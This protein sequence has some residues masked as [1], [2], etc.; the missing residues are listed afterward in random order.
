MTIAVYLCG[1]ESK[2]IDTEVIAVCANRLAPGRFTWRK[3][4][5]QISLE[6]IRVF[7]SDAKKD[8]NGALVSGSGDR[9]WML[10]PAGCQL[11]KQNSHLSN[12]PSE[13]RSRL[14]ADEKR[15]VKREKA[16][17]LESTAAQKV[18]EG[19]NTEI[20]RREAEQFFRIDDYI[21]GSARDRKVSRIINLLG[22][23]E[24][25]GVV[26]HAVANLLGKEA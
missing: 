15:W 16:R 13:T 18:K 9:G 1:G 22:D 5:E 10:T 20:T 14:S 2:P 25:L 3:Y 23:D 11:A 6:H 21:T 12:S 8:K 19:R 4:K 17:L 24:D 26:V 7:L